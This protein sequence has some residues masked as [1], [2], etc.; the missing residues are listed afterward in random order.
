[1][2]DWDKLQ[3]KD[4]QNIMKRL[5]EADGS[6]RLNYYC[7][8]KPSCD[9]FRYVRTEYKAAEASGCILTKKDLKVMFHQKY[10]E[11]GRQSPY[12]LDMPWRG[13]LAWQEAL[14]IR[15]DFGG[16]IF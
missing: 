5:A 3:A 1:M 4:F 8:W 7:E 12:K 11:L 14:R 2:D 10:D 15:A 16:L 13:C 6:E 9:A